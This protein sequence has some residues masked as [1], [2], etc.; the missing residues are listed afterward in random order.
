MLSLGPDS[1]QGPGGHP[2]TSRWFLP[3]CVMGIGSLCGVVVVGMLCAVC[4]AE[5]AARSTG[6]LC[7]PQA[8]EPQVL[9]RSHVQCISVAQHSTAW[10]L[11]SA[12][13][14]LLSLPVSHL[15]PGG[16]ELGV[17]SCIIILP[18]KLGSSCPGF[19]WALGQCLFWEPPTPTPQ[20]SP[21]LSQAFMRGGE[22]MVGVCLCVWCP[23][24]S[25][26]L[27]MS[28]LP[29]CSLPPPAPRGQPWVICWAGHQLCTRGHGAFEFL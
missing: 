4:A 12:P 27:Q 26:S 8:L 22:E 6:W 19:I 23:S 29:P 13:Q 10:P 18:L 5:P 16:K 14:E 11:V 20:L 3:S 1:L 21:S 7:H 2:C 25:H 24:N 15:C 17:G 9:M 28:R